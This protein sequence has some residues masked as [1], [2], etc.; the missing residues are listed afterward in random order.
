MQLHCEAGEG[1]QR[2][3]EERKEREGGEMGRR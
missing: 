3:E 2:R 1:R